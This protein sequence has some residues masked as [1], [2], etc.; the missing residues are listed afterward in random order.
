MKFVNVLLNVKEDTF[1]SF[2]AVFIIFTAGFMLQALGLI[3]PD[4]F[5]Y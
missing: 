4:L 3:M 5:Y 1:A 2:H